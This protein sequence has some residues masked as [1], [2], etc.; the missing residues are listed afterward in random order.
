MNSYEDS[1]PMAY[2]EVGQFACL[3]VVSVEPIGA[4]LDRGLSKDLFLPFREQTRHLEPGDYV[5]VYLYVDNTQRVCA[6]M[7]TNKY[8]EKGPG[9]YREGDRVQLLIADRTDLGYRAIIEDSRYGILYAN[10][11]FRSLSIG[12]RIEGFIK[13]IRPDGKID[14]RLEETGHR[15]AGNIGD[16][17]ADELERHGGFLPVHDGSPAEE[18]YDLLGISKKKFKM[19]VGGL[20]KKGVITLEPDGIRLLPSK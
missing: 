3:E 5:V 10:E 8:I 15:A 1:E 7:R 12:Q 13:R 17:I 16:R 11:V 14:L 9:D 4:F 6:S 18:I 20:Y 2:A 19:A